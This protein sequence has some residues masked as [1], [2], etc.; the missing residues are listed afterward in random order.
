MQTRAKAPQKGAAMHST[1][2]MHRARLVT[3]L[4]MS[5]LGRV[6]SVSR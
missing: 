1:V 3:A 6:A 4:Q 2:A 5:L